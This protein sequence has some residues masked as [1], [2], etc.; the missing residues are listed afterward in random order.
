MEAGTLKNCPSSG[1][2]RTEKLHVLH[3][4]RPERHY[5]LMGT[6]ERVGQTQGKTVR[7]GERRDVGFLCCSCKYTYAVRMFTCVRTRGGCAQSAC[8]EVSPLCVCARVQER[9]C[10]LALPAS[11]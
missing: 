10:L 2:P 1:S 5:S 4:S 7:H 3:L 11:Q 6:K 8:A 9:A